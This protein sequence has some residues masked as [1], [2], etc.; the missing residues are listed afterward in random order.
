[1]GNIFDDE[2]DEYAEQQVNT[3][4]VQASV[5]TAAPRYRRQHLSRKTL[6]WPK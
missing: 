4:T 3:P 6:S 2:L 1:M 5:P